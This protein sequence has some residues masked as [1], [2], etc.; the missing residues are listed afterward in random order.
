MP[1][2]VGLF[3]KRPR[4]DAENEL[5]AMLE[6]V[7]HEVFYVSGTWIDEAQ[8]I[9]VGWVAREGSFGDRMPLHNESREVTLCFSGEVERRRFSMTG[10]GCNGFIT[11]KRQILFTLQPKQRQ[12]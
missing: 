6:S 1:G 11:T 3:T 10:T 8:G 4:A 12:S 9:Y 7:C 5:R 2:I